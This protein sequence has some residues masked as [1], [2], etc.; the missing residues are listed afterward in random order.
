MKK[1]IFRIAAIAVFT[2]ALVPMTVLAS[3]HTSNEATSQPTVGDS[4]PDEKSPTKFYG[5]IT[6]IDPKAMTFTIGEQTFSVIG[7]TKMTKNG[8][9]ATIADAVVGE[10]ARGTYTKT[11]DGKLNVTKVNFGKKGGG[12]KSKKN[13]PAT[14]QSST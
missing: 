7:E 4:G 8:K 6:A 2:I 1:S 13:G 5:T 14:T 3:K 10:P 9:D 12:K 11:D